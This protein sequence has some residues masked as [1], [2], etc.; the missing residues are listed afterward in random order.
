MTQQA[1]PA[2]P[3]AAPS[4]SPARD[5]LHRRG[6]AF[7]QLLTRDQVAALL[8]AFDQQ[9]SAL[10]AAEAKAAAAVHLARLESLLPPPGSLGRFQVRGRE[11]AIRGRASQQPF[12]EFQQT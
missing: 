6:I 10:R 7:D 9:Q 8:T 12:A 3:A 1:T 4:P 2:T 5:F 11:R